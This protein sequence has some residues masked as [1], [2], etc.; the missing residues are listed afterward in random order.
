MFMISSLIALAGGVLLKG[1]QV[2][3]RRLNPD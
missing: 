1:S 2:A 3:A